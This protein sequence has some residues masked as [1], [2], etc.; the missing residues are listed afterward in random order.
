[1]RGGLVFLKIYFGLIVINYYIV[2]K[3]IMQC[4]VVFRGI[5]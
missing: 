3:Y 2:Y 1:M 4:K 5:K